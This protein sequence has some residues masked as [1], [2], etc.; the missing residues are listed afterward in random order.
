M[1]KSRKK[2]LIFVLGNTSGIPGFMNIPQ[3]QSHPTY[4]YVTL[5]T[6]SQLTTIDD[7]GVA[8]LDASYERLESG[9]DAEIRAR[10]ATPGNRY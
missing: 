4:R 9:D 3:R 8:T 10:A 2:F 7:G 1:V 5:N 6:G